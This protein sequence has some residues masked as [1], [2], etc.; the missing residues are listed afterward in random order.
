M[1]NVYN[2]S[3]IRKLQ[4][5]KMYQFEIDLHFRKYFHVMSVTITYCLI[6][7]YK[8]TCNIT[9]RKLFGTLRSSDIFFGRRSFANVKQRHFEQVL[10]QHLVILPLEKGETLSARSSFRLQTRWSLRLKTLTSH[11]LTKMLASAAVKFLNVLPRTTRFQ[12]YF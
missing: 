11:Y 4:A 12:V 2:K 9:Y 1:Q 8:I 6:N 5:N 3:A 10:L 7:I